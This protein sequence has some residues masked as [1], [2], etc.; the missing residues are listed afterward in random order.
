MSTFM[1]IMLVP[2]LIV[3]FSVGV[4]LAASGGGESD[5]P[6]AQVAPT[7]ATVEDVT[8]T[9]GTTTAGAEDVSGP[10]DEAE[11]ADDPRCTGPAPADDR[12]QGDDGPGDDDGRDD[13]GN[14][15]PGSQSSGP[16]HDDDDDD[17][18]RG[19]DDRSSHRGGDDDRHDDS[20]GHGRGGDDDR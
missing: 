19:H 7:T 14:S 3:A 4:A 20:G 17:D 8:T 13:D 18:D 1:K 2:A 15:G 6:L 10:C 11:H 5:S 12:D 9:A 16:S